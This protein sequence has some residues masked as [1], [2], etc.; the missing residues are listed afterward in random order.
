MKGAHAQLSFRHP[1]IDRSAVLTSLPAIVIV[2][3]CSGLPLL[4]LAGAILFASPAVR[5]ELHLN[6]FRLQLLLRT[7]AYNGL[8]AIFATLMGLPA[9][10]VLGRGRG[11]FTRLMWVIL[12]AAL[13]MPS[14][15]Y[16]YGWSQFARILRIFLTDHFG[17]DFVQRFGLTFIPAGP[18][19]TFRCIWSLAGWLW[20]VPAGLIGLSLRGLDS[21]VQQQALLDGAMLRVTLRQLLPA[22]T[23][24]LAV[25][26]I[27]ATQEFAVYEPTGI[28]VVATEV[29]MVFDTGAVSSPD[30]PI[31][32]PVLQG[33]GTKS[34]D[35]PARAA[36]AVTVAMPLVAITFLLALVVTFFIS[37]AEPGGSVT[38]AAWPQILNATWKSKAATLLFLT[39]NLGVP[40]WALVVSLRE[41]PELGAIGV[42]HKMWGSFEPQIIGAILVAALTAVLA[43]IAGFSSSAR[44]MR[45]LLFLTA[46]T[47]LIGGQ[48]L[49]IADIRIYNRPGL[50]WVY[51]YFPA[52]V[53]AYVG[54]FGWLALAASAAT[55]TKP[56]REIREMASVDG[57]STFQLA[58]R[59]IWPLAWPMLLAGGL[60]VGALSMTEVPATVLL[61]P[62]NPQV[63]TPTLMTWVHMAHYDAMIEASLLMMA[64]V[65]LP[66]IAAVLLTALALR[67]AQR[68]PTTRSQA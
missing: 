23:A 31:A 66:A 29:R 4:W 57:A 20:A 40:I 2:A 35:Q 3:I 10:F 68:F 55:W 25:V 32:G 19:D 30:N 39:L 1:R 51:D 16:A 22:I 5:A 24:S 65:L 14:L 52:P 28:S 45:A 67:I 47:F 49:A 8:A 42:I 33:L 64:V 13:L 41:L 27:I 44:R 6:S 56:W 9:A 53:L 50:F 38:V 62:Q 59:V 15:S 58:L 18:A 7:F 36:A 63:L 12:P 21:S 37:R 54:R 46:S 11:I 34:P 26:T 61:F 48:L 43:T 60:I 17:I